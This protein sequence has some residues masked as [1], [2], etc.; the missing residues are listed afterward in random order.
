MTQSEL[1][2]GI[3]E[4]L[5]GLYGARFRGLVLYGGAARGDAGEDSDIECH[6]F[7][8]IACTV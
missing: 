7:L 6:Y 1:L 3:K 5:Q 4:R 8:P 2:Q